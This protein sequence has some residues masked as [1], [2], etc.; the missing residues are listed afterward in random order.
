M[1]LLTVYF[2]LFIYCAVLLALSSSVVLRYHTEIY[3]AD[4]NSLFMGGDRDQHEYVQK[5]TS[6]VQIYRLIITAKSKVKRAN[7][8]IASYLRESAKHLLLL[9]STQTM[10]E[11]PGCSC[12]S[13]PI[14][15]ASRHLCRLFF[16]FV[17]A[18][19][20]IQHLVPMEICPFTS[21]FSETCLL[22][23]TDL[24][25]SHGRQYGR[26]QHLKC[27]TDC[28]KKKQSW[29]HDGERI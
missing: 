2:C 23:Q 6:A 14:V 13:A 11:I 7:P 19:E 26:I 9:D 17:F 12:L 15:A 28:F 16:P 18:P 21:I 10:E 24:P 27:L 5:L 4:T 25:R 8:A 20:L 3:G 29:S 1:L 22:M